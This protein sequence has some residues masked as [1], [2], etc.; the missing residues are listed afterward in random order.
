MNLFRAI[1]F[2]AVGLSAASGAV[3]AGSGPMADAGLDQSVSVN[4]TVQLDATGSIQ[5]DGEIGS[6]EWRIETPDS[7][8]IEPECVDCARTAFS[9]DTGGRYEVT[10]T[11]TGSDGETASDTLYVDV[12]I[13]E[14]ERNETNERPD[15]DGNYNSGDFTGGE[16]SGNNVETE[17]DDNG[18]NNGVVEYGLE[19]DSCDG[20]SQTGTGYVTTNVGDCTDIGDIEWNQPETRAATTE[21]KMELSDYESNSLLTTSPPPNHDVPESTTLSGESDPMATW[22]RSAQE[23]NT[24]IVEGILYGA[25]SAEVTQVQLSGEGAEGVSNLEDVNS[26][27]YNP[28]PRTGSEHGY[29][30]ARQTG[31]PTDVSDYDT[32]MVTYETDEG[33]GTFD[34]LGI[35][36]T[37]S[38]EDYEDDRSVV[39]EMANSVSDGVFNTLE[40]ASGLSVDDD[41]SNNRSSKDSGDSSSDWIA[42]PD[43][44]DGPTQDN[45][46]NRGVGYSTGSSADGSSGTTDGSSGDSTGGSSSNMD[47][48]LPDNLGETEAENSSGYATGPGI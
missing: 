7:R 44:N 37:Y 4:T 15:R 2:I 17:N 41:E 1:C 43:F 26:E 31:G 34:R 5:P 46:G 29:Q 24:G 42:D 14:R 10:V 45:S 36:D 16:T 33:T 32:V 28:T 25:D 39:S 35:S 6:Y 40:S 38:R 8:I 13:S 9:P 22:A 27:F 11:V 21:I 47:W 3:A 12:E 19:I 20:T 18:P 23:E 48:Q 30:D